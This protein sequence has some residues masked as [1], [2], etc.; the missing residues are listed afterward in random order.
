MEAARADL[1]STVLRP[2]LAAGRVVLCDRYDDSTLAYQGGG[3]GLDLEWLRRMNAF[4]TGGLK[5]DLTLLFDLSPEQ[6]LSRRRGQGGANRLDLE[7][8]AFHTRVR[9]AFLELASREPGRF[10]VIDATCE[11]ESA[12]ERVWQAFESRRAAAGTSAGG[13]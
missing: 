13:A 2:A 4:A 7:T 8:E 9:A 6:G 1:V 5:P 3:R 12:F 11:P 10:V